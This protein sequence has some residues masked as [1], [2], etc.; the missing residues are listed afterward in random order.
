MRHLQLGRQFAG[1]VS[2]EVASALLFPGS[3]DT[4]PTHAD[5]MWG[6]KVRV[7]VLSCTPVSLL[8]MK[9]LLHTWFGHA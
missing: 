3:G 6:N 7:S 1:G 5:L 4:V 9:P 8:R 2:E